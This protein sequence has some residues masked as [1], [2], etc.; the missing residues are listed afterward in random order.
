MNDS[1]I[2]RVFGQQLKRIRVQKGVT[3]ERLALESGY[4]PTYISYLETG[5][6]VPSLETVIKLSDSLEIELTV[7]LEPFIEK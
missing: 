5:K 1:S 6:Y 2:A 4:H 7:L 3:Q